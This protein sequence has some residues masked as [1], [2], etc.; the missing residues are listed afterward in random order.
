MPIKEQSKKA[1]RQMKRHAER[2]L[3]VREDLKTLM[4]KA[5]LA[6]DKKEAKDKIEALI[7]QTQKSLDK[8]AQKNVF[9]KNTVARKLSRLVKYHQKGGKTIKNEVKAKV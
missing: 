3:K 8:A 9:K 4:K 6:I 2:N 1:L 7:K 5:R